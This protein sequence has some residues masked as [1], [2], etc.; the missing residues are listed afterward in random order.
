[1]SDNILNALYFFQ[2]GR[3]VYEHG[4]WFC[5]GPIVTLT[6][7]LPPPPPPPPQLPPQDQKPLVHLKNITIA[8][9]ILEIVIPQQH[10]ICTKPLRCLVVNDPKLPLGGHL[11]YLLPPQLRVLR[12][13]RLQVQPLRQART[14]IY[15]I[16][17][18]TVSSFVSY[19]MAATQHVISLLYAFALRFLCYSVGSLWN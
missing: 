11:L 13:R 8:N 2:L 10:L 6:S 1:M 4:S 16:Y 12:S 17:G 14:E 18:W 15:G 19:H 3:L 7:P 5:T 9:I